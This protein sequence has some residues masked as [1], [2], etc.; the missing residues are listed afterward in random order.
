MVSFLTGIPLFL[1][2][3]VYVATL[4]RRCP[5]SYGSCCSTHEGAPGVNDDEAWA[6][7]FAVGDA[8][9]DIQRRMAGRGE[10]REC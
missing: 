9:L 3:G 10:Q 5:A 8:H 4:V 6:L 1:R 7:P 2:Q